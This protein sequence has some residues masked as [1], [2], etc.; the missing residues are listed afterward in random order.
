VLITNFKIMKK[1]NYLVLVSVLVSGFLVWGS[2]A[3]AQSDKAERVG[4][5][6]MNYP[7]AELGNCKN[8]GDCKNYCEQS[9]NMSACVA[10]AE[11][12]QLLTGEDLRLSKIVATKISTGQ[13]PGNCK[14]R[15]ECESFCAG[16]TENINAC[17]AFAEELGILPK[18]ELEQAKNIAAALSSGAILPGGCKTKGDCENYCRA[19]AHIDECLTFAE[20]AKLM[21]PE[22]LTQVRAMAEYLKAGTTPGGCKTKGECESYCAEEANFDECVSFAEK[23]GMI[24]AEE[25]SLAKKAG[26]VGPGGCRGTEECKAYCADE[27]NSDECANF[28]I[29]KGLISKEDQD[30]MKAGVDEINKAFDSMP[31][32]MAREARNCLFTKIGAPKLASILDKTSPLTKVTGEAFNECFKEAG[33]SYKESIQEGIKGQIQKSIGGRESGQFGAPA[34]IQEQIQKQMEGRSS[35]G[36]NLNLDDLSKVL[37]PNLSDEDRANYEKLIRESAA[38]YQVPNSKQEYLNQIPPSTGSTMGPI[39]Q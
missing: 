21:T 39:S 15:T 24:S 37:P 12:N 17:V 4:L 6:N 26:G 8:Q 1:Q 5:D 16:K 25:A 22:E 33:D 2:N 35:V 9:E 36:G 29:A 13:T 30:K 3:L 10:Y 11:K 38:G 28:A 19:G 14:T 31:V 34:D 32:V 23:T 7:I 27:A 20:S 18:A